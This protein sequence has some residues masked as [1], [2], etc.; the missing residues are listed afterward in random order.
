MY[1]EEV[2]A[3]VEPPD[4]SQSQVKRAEALVERKSGARSQPRASPCKPFCGHLRNL[5]QSAPV[6]GFQRQRTPGHADFEFRS[7]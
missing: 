6:H 1:E 4:K 2:K 7:V 5:R 3:S